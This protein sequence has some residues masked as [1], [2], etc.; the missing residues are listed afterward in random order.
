[1]WVKCK[2]CLPEEG[3]DVPNFTITDKKLLTETKTKSSIS[4]VKLLMDKY[5]LTHL[6]S[7]YIVTHINEKFG[8]CNRCN[9]TELDQEYITCPKCKALNLNWKF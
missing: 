6:E 8:S 7:K 1:M 2:N 5:N 9:Y 3:I 4:A